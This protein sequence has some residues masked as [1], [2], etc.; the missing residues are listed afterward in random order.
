DSTGRYAAMYKPFHLIGLELSISVL[1]VALRGEP[2]GSCRAWR[3]DAVAV[4]KRALK[5]GETLDGEGGY[6][7]YAKLIPATRSLERNAL[8]IGLA[9]HVKALR[10]IAGGE[11]VCAADVALDG[12]VQ[13]VRIRRDM[14]QEARQ[15][16]DGGGIALIHT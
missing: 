11:I 16:G 15:A 4:A 3:G 8:P 14:E 1:N 9:H 7:V 12:T 6:T 2:T 5:A 13:A 10:D